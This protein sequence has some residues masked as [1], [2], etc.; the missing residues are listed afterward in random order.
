MGDQYVYRYIRPDDTSLYIGITNNLENRIAQH[1]KDILKDLTG[2]VRIQWLKV[3][4]RADAE[5]LET[6]LICR[7]IG[8]G[9]LRNS[10][11]TKKGDV[12][13]LDSVVFPWRDLSEFPD[14]DSVP[15]FQPI[16]DQVQTKTVI[17]N[18]FVLARSPSDL[19]DMRRQQMADLFDDI[20]GHKDTLKTE[21]FVMCACYK[22]N[23]ENAEF[24]EAWKHLYI[25]GLWQRKECLRYL[26]LVYQEA[27]NGYLG[28]IWT[29]RLPNLERL[30]D[31]TDK[32]REIRDQYESYEIAYSKLI[33]GYTPQKSD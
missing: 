12:S 7:E 32:Y 31:Y 26:D 29:G 4:Y 18:R 33:L 30:L 28:F 9:A 17:K 8:N 22:T 25:Y 16:K 21:L 1:T 24:R 13:F 10:A 11:K 15:Y 23:I 19:A 6:Y 3:K 2:K 27:Q 14:R 20:R 5:L